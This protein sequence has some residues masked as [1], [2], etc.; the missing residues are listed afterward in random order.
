MA[1][2]EPTYTREAAE[3]IFDWTFIPKEDQEALMPDWLTMCPKIDLN[4]QVI[5]DA[6]ENWLPYTKN[7]EYKG[8]RMA[9]GALLREMVEIEK[10]NRRV[11][12]GE[13]VRSL[14]GVMPVVLA[15]YQTIKEAGGDDVYVGFPDMV[16]MQTM[17]SVFHHADHLFEEA[18]S[19]GFSYGARHCA[20]NKMGIAGRMLDFV[21][22]PT[23]M[24]SWGMVCD[25]ATKLDEWIKAKK[26]G[27][28]VSLVTRLPHDTYWDDEDYTDEDRI[29]YLAGSMRRALD[30][31]ADAM[32]VTIKP[33]DMANAL[34]KFGDYMKL[35]GSVSAKVA[36]ADPVPMRN[37]CLGILGLPATF[38]FNS[39]LEHLTEACKVL[40]E[41]IDQA[42]A[43]GRGVAPKGAPKVG[44]YFNPGN[45]PWFEAQMNKN[46]VAI[47]MSI[48]ATLLPQQMQ[49]SK[50]TDPYEQMAE[51]WLLYNFG[52]GCGCDTRIWVEKVR[53]RKCE[54]MIVG[55]LDYDRW[56][57]Q[58]QKVGAKIVEDE[59]GIP[60]FY[61]EADF[62]DDRDYSEEALKT[63]IETM[64]SIIK[65]NQRK[66]KVQ[67]AIEAAA[68]QS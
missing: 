61:V 3:F 56:L 20:L 65:M 60:T 59:L 54:G 62:Y 49:P 8:M 24:W 4:D 43:E 16:I 51:T 55:F 58:V 41:E 45:N 50:Y 31:C 52:M 44:M 48:P 46:G 57:G 25:E 21:P 27:N 23:V 68:Q 17:Q 2:N 32:G 33:E 10:L 7:V 67:E 64:C 35:Y 15:P 40:S 22:D 63:R 36:M 26:K 18:E 13:N 42:I 28:W 1:A 9:I 6:V 38:P 14:Y 29:K 12:A 11:K 39:G 30:E 34:K 53:S 19:K 5:Y 37:N 47:N 66:R